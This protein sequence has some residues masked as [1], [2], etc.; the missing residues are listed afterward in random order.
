MIKNI[1]DFIAKNLLVILCICTF[2][3]MH[4]DL[5]FKNIDSFVIVGLI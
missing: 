5:D 1:H 2:V 3:L 4:K